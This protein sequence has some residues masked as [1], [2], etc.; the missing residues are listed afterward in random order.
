MDLLLDNRQQEI[1]ITN[2]MIE[3]LKEVIKECLNI[4]SRTEDYELSISIVD[5]N[6]IMKLNKIYMGKDRPTDVLSFPMEDNTLFDGQ[7]PMLGDIV[8]SAIT[9]KR[10]SEEFGHSF[11]RE[12]AYLTA[13][14]MFHL[15]GYDH[16]EEQEKNIMREKEKQVMKNLGLFK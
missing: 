7:L 8:I 1:E 14:S 3:M 9:A 6:E 10:Q 11:E 4:E 15:M 2:E 12:M 13:H 16:M 5:D